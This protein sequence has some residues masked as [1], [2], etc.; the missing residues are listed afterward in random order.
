MLVLPFM[1]LEWVNRREFHEEFPLALFGILWLLPFIFIAILLPLVKD[2]CT[3]A[4]LLANPV[5]LLLRVG[6]LTLVTVLWV[7]TVIDQ[8]P[9]FL[10]IPFCD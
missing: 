7:G 10:G 4:R 5:M 6:I 9:C 1:I 3:G 8:L 2:I